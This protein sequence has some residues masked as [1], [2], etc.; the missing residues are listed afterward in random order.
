MGRGIRLNDIKKLRCRSA[1]VEATRLPSW[2]ITSSG[3]RTPHHQP[4]VA[5][6]IE[7][8]ESGF[9][10]LSATTSIWS[11]KSVPDTVSR[12][13]EFQVHIH[14]RARVET[15]RKRP[16]SW[17]VL[18]LRG[19]RDFENLPAYRRFIDEVVGRRNARNRKRIEIERAALKPLPDRRT[20]DYEEAR[21]LVTSRGG[22]IL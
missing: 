12:S 15:V 1:L 20:A 3:E 19:S 2:A 16:K 17:S 22:F 21:V 11:P 9:R 6:H 8:V 18:L 5:R 13:R 14:P 10:E 7:R 4:P